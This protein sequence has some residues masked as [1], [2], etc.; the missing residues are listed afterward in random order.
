M[1]PVIEL[2]DNQKNKLLNDSLHF[3]L[4]GVNVS[5]ANSIRRTILS[6]IETLVFRTTPYEKNRPHHSPERPGGAHDL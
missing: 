4:S 5:L 6:D 3:R 1:N 2:I